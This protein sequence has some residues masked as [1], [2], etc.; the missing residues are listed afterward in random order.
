MFQVLML[1]NRQPNP[2]LTPL[3]PDAHASC[4][5]GVWTPQRPWLRAT[6]PCLRPLLGRPPGLSRRRGGWNPL[7][8][9]AGTSAGG[10]FCPPLG[11][12]CG[13]DDSPRGSAQDSPAGVTVSQENQEAEGSSEPAKPVTGTCPGPRG[14]GDIHL[15]SNGRASKN[16]LTWFFV[17]V[18]LLLFPDYHTRET[19]S[20]FLSHCSQVEILESDSLAAEFPVPVQEATGALVLNSN[21]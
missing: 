1:H 12:P 7:A 5:S 10:P 11:S 8:A 9:P 15:P 17:F 18:C 13:L 19:L 20:K 2:W 6:P 16:L 4:G 14:G 21:S 3:F